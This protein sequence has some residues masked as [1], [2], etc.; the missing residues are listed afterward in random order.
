MI[1]ISNRNRVSN[2]RGTKMKA[3]LLANLNTKEGFIRHKQ[4][5]QFLL[6]NKKGNLRPF[7]IYLSLNRIKSS[8]YCVSFQVL[9]LQFALLWVGSYLDGAVLDLKVYIVF[10]SLAPS[11]T[12]LREITHVLHRNSRFCCLFRRDG[13]FHKIFDPYRA[14][15]HFFL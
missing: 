11:C 8:N 12:V 1:W 5:K 7:S 10:H 9:P 2:W 13:I 6:G 14:K 4:H 15:M 3:W